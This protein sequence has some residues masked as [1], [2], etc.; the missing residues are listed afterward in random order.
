MSLRLTLTH[1]QP[2]AS[3][4]RRRPSRRF[5]LLQKSA[6]GSVPP[7]QKNS[8]VCRV[9]KTRPRERSVRPCL[10]RLL[11]NPESIRISHHI[12]TQKLSPVVIYDEQII[13]PSPTTS[14]SAE[15][16]DIGARAIHRSLVALAT[17]PVHSTLVWEPSLAFFSRQPNPAAGETCSS[18]RITILKRR[19]PSAAT[20]FVR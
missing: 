8:D 12:E 20:R 10:P 6:C 14:S 5:R 17:C 15:I 2:A 7:Y 18:H 11:H 16:N 3:T 4:H 13:V 19:H 9:P 1:E